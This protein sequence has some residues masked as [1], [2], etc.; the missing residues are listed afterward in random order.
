MNWQNIMKLNKTLINGSLFSIFSFFNQGVSF[1]LLIL[2]ANYIL[3]AEYGKLS[4]FNTI[5]T[6]MGYVIAL[7]TQGYISISFFQNDRKDFSKDFSVI[8]A[9]SLLIFTLL[10]VIILTGRSYLPGLVKFD[11]SLL[12]VALLITF[13]NLM[14]GILLDYYR[15]RE[16]VK[17]YGAFSCSFAVVNFI[18]TLFLVISCDM[19]WLGRVYAQLLTCVIGGIIAV[20]IFYK[21]KLLTT[22]VKDIDRFKR[23]IV[24]GL[25]LIPHL[26]AMWI[27]QGGDRYIIDYFHQIDDVGL[28]SFA[29]NLANIIVIIGIS[30]NS[31]NSVSI[32]QVLSDTSIVDKIKELKKQKNQILLIYVAATIAVMLGGALFVPLALPKYSGSIQYFLILSVSGFF[33]CLYFLY[34]NFLFYY[35]KNKDIMYVTFG[36]SLLHLGLS[37]VFT[38]YSL[39]YTCCIYI[40]IQFIIFI[41]IKRQAMKVIRENVINHENN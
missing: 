26:A 12:W 5:V 21:N 15:I 25:P 29:L 20:L 6:F 37:L 13:F 31:S 1:V 33:Q 7:S 23:I 14:F 22:E 10:A 24:W 38:R 36:T 40:L 2:L 27:K 28:F 11:Y 30:F 8:M 9:V 16:Q 18:L 34:C 4:L 39:I 3:P 17:I 41:L 35:K 19:S 32:Y